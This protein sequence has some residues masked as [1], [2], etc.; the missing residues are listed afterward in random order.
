[1]QALVLHEFVLYIRHIYQNAPY[2]F[3]LK[4]FCLHRIIENI[5]HLIKVYDR[6]FVK[7]DMILNTHN[8]QL[9]SLY[10]F[11]WPLL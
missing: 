11:L 6:K 4:I 9:A 1:M 10:Y 7:Y 8:L 2:V 5:K 3:N